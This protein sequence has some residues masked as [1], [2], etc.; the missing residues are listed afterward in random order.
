[1][2]PTYIKTT[3]T[4]SSISSPP[5]PLPLGLRAR[6]RERESFQGT[7]KYPRQQHFTFAKAAR[8]VTPPPGAERSPKRSWRAARMGRQANLT[9][10][11]SPFYSL[12]FTLTLPSRYHHRKR[13]LFSCPCFRKTFR[14]DPL[15]R[16]NGRQCSQGS[17]RP[18][19]RRLHAIMPSGCF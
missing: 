12:G 7:T 18:A 3:T 19:L 4:S 5:P 11:S 13:T 17:T 10:Q 15:G 9:G 1:M 14:Y 2:V 8:R 6:E 16:I